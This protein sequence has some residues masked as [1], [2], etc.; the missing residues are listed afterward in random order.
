[1][2]TTFPGLLFTFRP[3]PFITLIGF[4]MSANNSGSQ[5]LTQELEIKVVWVSSWITPQP[6]CCRRSSKVQVGQEVMLVDVKL[7]FSSLQFVQKNISLAYELATYTRN[8]EL[9]SQFLSHLWRY[10]FCPK[11]IRHNVSYIR[12]T[13]IPWKIVKQVVGCFT[14]SFC[15]YKVGGKGHP[16]P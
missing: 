6:L 15:F 4:S 14:L 1:M 11:H 9:L 16:L 5:E 8:L 12:S 2:K 7:Q 10:Q 13:A 3:C